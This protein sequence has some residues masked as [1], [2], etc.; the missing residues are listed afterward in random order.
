MLGASACECDST[1]WPLPS[2]LER[3][4][5]PTIAVVSSEGHSKTLTNRP[6]LFLA[7][8]L[9]LQLLQHSKPDQPTPSPPQTSDARWTPRKSGAPYRRP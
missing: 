9:L 4:E 1:R 8:H 2:P 5:R 7:S 3:V 6:K